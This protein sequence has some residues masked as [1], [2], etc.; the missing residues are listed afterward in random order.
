MKKTAYLTKRI[1]VAASKKEGV[2]AANEA[3]NIMGYIVTSE[4]GWV[5]KKYADGTVEKVKEIASTENLE[6]ILD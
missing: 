3:M 1:L 4:K 6:L 2:K 5:V